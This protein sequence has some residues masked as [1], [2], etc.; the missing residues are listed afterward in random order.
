MS[1]VSLK[2]YF[3]ITILYLSLCPTLQ[4]SKVPLQSPKGMRDIMGEEYYR[5]QGLFEEGSRNRR[6]LRI[7]ADRNADS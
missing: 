3:T 5:F 7:Q 1:L 6:V 2:F 4:P